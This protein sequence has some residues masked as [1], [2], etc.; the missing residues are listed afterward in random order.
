VGRLSGRRQDTVW[1]NDVDMEMEGGSKE[2]R[3]LEEINLRGRDPKMC[4][5]TAGEGEG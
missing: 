5:S 4:R 3:R 2:E 1:R